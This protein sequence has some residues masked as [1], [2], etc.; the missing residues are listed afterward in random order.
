[1]IGY[2]RLLTKYNFMSTWYQIGTRFFT[3]YDYTIQLLLKDPY[4]TEVLTP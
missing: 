2:R 4:L 1:M 3:K